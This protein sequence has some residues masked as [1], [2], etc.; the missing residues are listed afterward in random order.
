MVSF[1]TLGSKQLLYVGH[2]VTVVDVCKLIHN[3][4]ML[5][6]VWWF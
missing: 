6:C 4:N 2:L 1:L 5:C 3:H